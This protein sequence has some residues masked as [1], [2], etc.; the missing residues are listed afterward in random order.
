MR[1]EWDEKK[2][3]T[4][5]GKHK[6]DFTDVPEVFRNETITILDERF[7]YQKQRNIR[8][9]SGARCFGGSYRR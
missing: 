8:L 3:L 5:L 4:N 1:Y 6:I 7:D 2:R 9:A